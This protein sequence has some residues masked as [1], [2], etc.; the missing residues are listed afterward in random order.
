MTQA[1]QVQMGNLILGKNQVWFDNY[2]GL[3][4]DGKN[5]EKMCDSN[6]ELI[7]TTDSI[8]YSHITEDDH[9]AIVSPYRRENDDRTNEKLMSQFKGEVRDS[10]YGFIQF[11]SRWAGDGETI[12][13]SSLLIPNCTKEDALGFGR[14][15]HQS[16]VIVRDERGCNEICTTDF[17]DE[18]TKYKYGDI[19]RTYDLS[20]N[21]VMSCDE[22]EAIFSERL[23]G[24]ASMPKNK[25]GLKPLRL[26]EVY[27]ISQSRPSYF[28]NGNRQ[29]LILNRKHRSE[30]RD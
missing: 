8:V 20:G 19:A 25:T 11:V 12:V 27:E 26:S 29:K 10:G 2:T 16:S 5:S 9:W 1:V 3:D 17:E 24:P 22:A 4:D 7:K 30:K 15:Y 14:K 23:G 21:K 6:T 18:N 28:Q 13:E